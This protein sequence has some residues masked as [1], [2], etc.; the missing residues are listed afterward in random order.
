M[1]SSDRRRSTE[2]TAPMIYHCIRCQTTTRRDVEV[3]KYVSTAIQCQCG[4]VFS[5]EAI[6]GKN[7][8]KV[9]ECDAR[10]LGA[11][12]HI[13]DCPGVGANHGLKYAG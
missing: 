6:K 11:R 9:Q 1:I 10:G 8:G 12:R 4:R 7:T 5:G 3:G 2:M 13:C